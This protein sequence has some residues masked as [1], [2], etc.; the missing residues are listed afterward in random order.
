MAS[1]VAGKGEADV[2]IWARRAELAETINLYH[3]N[4][5]YLPD[6]TL[7][8]TLR[9]SNELAEVLEGA[10]VVVM[11]V[12]SHGFR[13]VLTEV[14]SLVGDTACCYVSLTKGLEVD[15]RK[16][17]SEVIAEVVEGVEPRNV[18]VLTGPNLA[19]EIA[20]GFPAA[21]TIACA[22]DERAQF[23]QE[24][25]H[26]DRFRCYRNTD[27]AGSEIG[28]AL[29]NVI[30]IAAGIADGLGFNGRYPRPGRDGSFRRRLRCSATD[31][32]GS[33]RGRRPHGDLRQPPI[34]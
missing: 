4:P 15:T 18:A 6:I 19:K 29:K 5:P 23:L 34:S 1:V 26:T 11:A 32:V 12:P 8:E 27:V 14:A 9:A 30:A 16:R 24:L 2:M 21:S 13:G 28:G 31:L 7:P 20:Q 10:E 22:D 3:E 33:G 17:M 25:I